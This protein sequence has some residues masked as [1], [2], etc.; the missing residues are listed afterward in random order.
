ML[1]ATQEKLSPST[2]ICILSTITKK[3]DVSRRLI[4]P[5]AHLAWWGL[6]ERFL[7]LCR[8]YLG[9][10]AHWVIEKLFRL[11]SVYLVLKEKKTVGCENSQGWWATAKITDQKTILKSDLNLRLD[12]VWSLKGALFKWSPIKSSIRYGNAVERFA[13]I[14]WLYLSPGTLLSTD[15]QCDSSLSPGAES[16]CALR[17]CL[18]VIQQAVQNTGKKTAPLRCRTVLS[19]IPNSVWV[20]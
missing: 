19:Q 5:Q 13:M 11:I 8:E 2:K 12:A 14:N 20:C 15:T 17:S 6:K 16:V 10:F 4:L 1:I 9:C 18:G 3:G 7:V